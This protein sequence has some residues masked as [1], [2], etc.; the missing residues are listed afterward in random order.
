[1]QPARARAIARI[2]GRTRRRRLGELTGLRS[3][4]RSFIVRIVY[5]MR[6]RYEAGSVNDTPAHSLDARL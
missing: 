3:D 1:M 5:Q 4:A 2:E 6:S